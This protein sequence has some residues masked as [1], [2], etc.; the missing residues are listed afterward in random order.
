MPKKVNYGGNKKIT[1][2][3]IDSEKIVRNGINYFYEAKGQ[4]SKQ[5]LTIDACFINQELEKFKRVLKVL[6]KSYPDEGISDVRLSRKHIVIIK[7][8]ATNR[9]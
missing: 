5:L 3:K 4:L 7:V 9:W 2:Q 8:K 1:I 6:Q